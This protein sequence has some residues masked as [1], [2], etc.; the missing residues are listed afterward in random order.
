LRDELNVGKGLS[1]EFIVEL[2]MVG[3]KFDFFVNV[4]EAE[5]VLSFLLEI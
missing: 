3:H 2:F 1:V 5:E 4:L